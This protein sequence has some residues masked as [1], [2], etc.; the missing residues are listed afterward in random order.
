M[1]SNSSITNNYRDNSVKWINELF[2]VV[3]PTYSQVISENLVNSVQPMLDIYRPSFINSI[4]FNKCDMGRR[5]LQFES[6]VMHP[7]DPEQ[8]N[9]VLMDLNFSFPSDLDIQLGLKVGF[10]RGTIALQNFEIQGRLRVR[11]D[12]LHKPPYIGTLGVSFYENPKIDFKI[13]PLVGFDVKDLPGLAGFLDS[14]ISK[15]LTGMMVLPKELVIP[16]TSENPQ[17][18][19]LHIELKSG[20]NLAIR[21]I[22]GTSDP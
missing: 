17:K 1:N 10:L 21:D 5:P 8:P 13:K 7:I 15:T 9:L 11:M 18:Y 2:Q 12:I 6:T 16:L 19:I 3:W 4:K 22:G 20:H 14:F